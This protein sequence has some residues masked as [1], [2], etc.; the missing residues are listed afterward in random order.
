M[1]NLGFCMDKDKTEEKEESFGVC[2]TFETMLESFNRRDRHWRKPVWLDWLAE[3]ER[4]SD[5]SKKMV[6]KESS[7]VLKKV[8]SFIV[9][10]SAIMDEF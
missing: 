10:F 5:I 3:T 6:V 9:Y 8:W 4:G 7:I 2:M 1:E